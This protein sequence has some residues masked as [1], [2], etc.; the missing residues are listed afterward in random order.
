MRKLCPDRTPFHKIAPP[1]AARS[2]KREGRLDSQEKGPMSDRLD[3][4]V[5]RV[6]ALESA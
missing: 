5:E 6:V 4:L 1:A 3:E 2:A